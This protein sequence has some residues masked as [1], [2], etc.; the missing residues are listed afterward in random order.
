MI[1]LPQELENMKQLTTLVTAGFNDWKRYGQVIVRQ[2]GDLLMFSYSR[3]A[4]YEHRWNWFERV[5]RGLII[6]RLTG[7]VIARP[8]DKFFEWG[9]SGRTTNAPVVSVE[10]KEDG[11]LGVLYVQ[12]SEYKIA[13]Q[14]GF[15]SPPAVWA[16]ER[17]KKHLTLHDSAISPDLTLLFEIVYKDNQIV[18]E[19]W[20]DALILLAARDRHTGAYLGREKVDLIADLYDF[21]RPQRYPFTTVKE[22]LDTL[23]HLTNTEGYVVTFAD[24][25]RFKFKGEQYKRMFKVLDTCYFSDLV[26]LCERGENDVTR[27][28][29]SEAYK[30]LYDEWVAKILGTVSA[31]EQKANEAFSQAPQ[32]AGRKAFAA[33]V[34]EHHKDIA[35]YLFCLLD[36]RE[37]RPLIYKMAFKKEKSESLFAAKNN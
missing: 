20:S 16:T 31:L 24:G 29:I 34:N 21:P 14:R 10:S 18:V 6:H 15:D 27:G 32:T 28:L 1:A 37:L 12:D 3:A 22:V 11:S 19:Y 33:W 9:E 30:P 26:T 23:P 13:T 36:G 2:K 25:Q 7:E 5:S 8:F 17:L 35:S 4:M